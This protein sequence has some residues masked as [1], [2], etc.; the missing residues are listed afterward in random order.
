[1]AAPTDRAGPAALQRVRAAVIEAA[2]VVS[3]RLGAPD[4]PTHRRSR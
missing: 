2:H 4:P 1:V 3:R